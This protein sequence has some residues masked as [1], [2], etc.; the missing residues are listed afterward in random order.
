M[1][2]LIPQIDEIQRNI[3]RLAGPEVARQ[4]MEGREQLKDSTKPP[5]IAMWVQGAM[6]RLDALV[7]QTTREQVMLNC[8]YNCALVNGVAIK[9]AVAR[10]KKHST[11]DAFLEAE[12]QAPPT[13]T[14]LVREGDVVYQFYTPG[15]YIRPM[16]CYCSLLRGLPQDQTASLAY[17]QCSRGFV[18]KYWEAI[19]ETPIEVD[20]LE[21]AVSGAAECKFAIHLPPAGS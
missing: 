14:R 6:E 7:D 4:V 2:R 18:Q 9:R 21:S 13:G 20:L 15:E 1:G 12:Q 11:I 5:K 19:F 10:R 8:G 3:E 16:R 17:C